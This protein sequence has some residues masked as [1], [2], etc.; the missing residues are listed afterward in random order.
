MYSRALIPLDGSPESEAILPFVL[1]IAGPLDLE[2]VLLRVLE[3]MVPEVTEASRHVVVEDV[4]ARQAD[5]REYL[6]PL[7]AGLR[8][9]GIR[10]RTEVRR[11]VPAEEIAAAARAVGADVI[12]M[13]THGRSGLGRLLFGSVAEAVLRGADVPVLLMRQTAAALAARAAAP[14]AR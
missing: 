10:T 4:E 7:A 14:A 2:V 12:A 8:G 13:T 1:D 9:R 5:A 6:S 3:P 11:G